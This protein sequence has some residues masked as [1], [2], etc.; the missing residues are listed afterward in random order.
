MLN[1]DFL[2]DLRWLVRKLDHNVES[3]PAWLASVLGSIQSKKK[4]LGF[5]ASNDQLDEYPNNQVGL[6]G[7]QACS[8]REYTDRD[9]SCRHL[10]LEEFTR[11]ESSIE[12][13]PLPSI[14]CSLS[15]LAQDIFFCHF[16][17]YSPE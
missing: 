14:D 16:K 15:S 1:K 8:G 3:K 5:L 11:L 13:V 17:D 12:S 9:F 2:I 6:L 4:M 10:Y 7:N